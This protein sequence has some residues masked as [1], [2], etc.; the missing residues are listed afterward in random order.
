MPSAHRR[1]AQWTPD[2]LKRQANAIGNNTGILIE[3]I[4]RERRH[5]EQGFRACTGIIRLAKAYG[6][7][8]LEAACERALEINARSYSS[9]NS[10]LKTNY[11][12]RR[13]HRTTEEP[14][15]QHTNIR[16]ANYF[17]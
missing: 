15:I 1:Y 6:A 16:G 14:A 13:P 7:E 9:V 2:K 5:P 4:M 11:D 8:R 17:H 10:I 3:V 12:Q